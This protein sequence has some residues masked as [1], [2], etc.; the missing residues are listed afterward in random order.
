M[1]AITCVLCFAS[2]LLLVIASCASI[3]TGTTQ[4]VSITSNVDGATIFLDGE[5]IGTTPFY[6]VISKNKKQLRIAKEGYQSEIVV[7]SKSL[8]PMFWGN[9]ITGGTL[10]SITDF[11]SGAAYTYSPA[12]Y[13]IDLK[14]QGQ[15]S[16]EYKQ[17]LVARKF[18][19]IYIDEISRDLSAG[20]GDHLSALMQITG[21]QAGHIR[22]A[23]DASDGRQVAF[24]RAIVALI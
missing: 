1:K 24:G 12:A 13:Q 4:S 14:A 15:S 5:Q 3:T 6:G 17:Q 21:L 19:M 16:L 23:L 20:G 8:E 7:L 18:S 9:I 2:V 22:D 10:G 11:A